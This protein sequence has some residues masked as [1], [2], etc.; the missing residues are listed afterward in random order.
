[1]NNNITKILDY[2]NYLL[3]DNE[4]KKKLFFE[5]LDLKLKEIN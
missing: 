2:Y 4:E 3:H 5:E 1:M